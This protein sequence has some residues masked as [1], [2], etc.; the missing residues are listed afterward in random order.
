MTDLTLAT[1]EPELA[2]VRHLFRQ[3]AASLQIDLCFQNFEHELA[4][5]P[6]AYASPGGALFLCRVD[7]IPAGCIGLRP[8]F[9]SV[10]ELKR[11]FV[12]PEFRGRGLGRS[13]ISAAINAAG[14]IGYESL[15]LDTLA[16]MERAIAL[17]QSFGFQPSAAYY[18]NPL[19]GVLYFRLRLMEP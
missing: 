16:T 2:A 17:Y 8:F 7:D 14:K 1:T 13:L 4:T 12:I 6:G 11:L 9:D 5:L 3:Y 18:P 19:P 15:V 10:G